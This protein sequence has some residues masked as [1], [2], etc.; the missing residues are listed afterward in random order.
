[1]KLIIHAVRKILSKEQKMMA[2]IESER[3]TRLLRQILSGWRFEG[4]IER[5]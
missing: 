3:R 4:K 1:M 2:A 5:F